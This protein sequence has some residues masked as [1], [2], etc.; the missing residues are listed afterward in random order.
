M[1]IFDRFNT[2]QAPAPPFFLLQAQRLC[3]KFALNKTVNQQGVCPSFRFYR[4]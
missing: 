1:V 4:E 3:I 2:G